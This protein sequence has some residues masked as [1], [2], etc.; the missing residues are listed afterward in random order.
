MCAIVVVDD[1]DPTFPS[2]ERDRV[3]VVIGEGLSYFE[4]LR[5]VRALLACL[6]ATQLGVGATCWCG[7]Y[8]AVPKPL[9]RVPRQRAVAGFKEARHA[10]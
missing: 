4:A 8:V 6:G 3:A 7:E 10:G 2:W 5:Q 1:V 9:P